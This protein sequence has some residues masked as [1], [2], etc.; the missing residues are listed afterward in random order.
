MARRGFVNTLWGR[1]CKSPT[2]ELFADAQQLKHVGMARMV[3]HRIFDVIE[4][5]RSNHSVYPHR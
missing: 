3:A 1:C 5:T 4:Q 2:F